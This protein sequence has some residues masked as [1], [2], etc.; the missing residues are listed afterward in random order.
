MCANKKTQSSKMS[1]QVSAERG[2]FDDVQLH[3]AQPAKNGKQAPLTHDGESWNLTFPG[4]Y[5]TSFN[6]SAF[7]DPEANRVTRSITADEGLQQLAKK[8]DEFLLEK[9]RK[10][11]TKFLGRRCPLRRWT[12]RTRASCAR[13][14]T[15][16]PW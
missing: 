3:A 1:A 9:V 12:P 5:Q 2:L 10:D 6:A 4:T 14:A 11:P 8:L 13:M 15:M 7:Q 16:R